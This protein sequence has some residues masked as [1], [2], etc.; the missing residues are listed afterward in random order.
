ML[1]TKFQGNWPG[2]SREEEFL[3]FWAWKP[4]WSCE[5]DHLTTIT[6]FNPILDSHE[7]YYNLALLY[8]FKKF[9]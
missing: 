8:F 7:M 3:R 6:F 4:S 1:H 9:F 5:Y 2:I